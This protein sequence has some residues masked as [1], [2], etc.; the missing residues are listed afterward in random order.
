MKEVIYSYG[1]YNINRFLVAL[2]KKHRNLQVY[3]KID[4]MIQ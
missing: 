3:K 1:F 4:F 2:S